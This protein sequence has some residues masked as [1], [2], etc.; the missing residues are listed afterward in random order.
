MIVRDLPA[1]R[2]MASRLALFAAKPVNFYYALKGLAL[3]LTRLPGKGG[4]G[5]FQFWFFAWTNAVLK[6]QNI[7]DDDFD[8]DSVDDDFD[9]RRILP[10][11]YEKTADERIPQN[12]IDAQ[13]RATTSQLSALVERRTSADAQS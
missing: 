12:K 10:E 13:L 2:Q 11:A 4:F 7:S 8:I 3:A 1:L 9:I 6:Y 5:Y